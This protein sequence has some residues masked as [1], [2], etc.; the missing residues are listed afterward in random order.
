MT[1][2]IFET[3]DID[4]ASYLTASTGHPPSVYR[5]SA[6]G[7]M[8]FHFRVDPEING[9]IVGYATGAAVTN[10]RRVLAARRQLFHE[11]RRVQREGRL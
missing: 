10:V 5:D 8:T 11:I 6:T 1:H 2:G 9:Q 7:L 4:L 3:T